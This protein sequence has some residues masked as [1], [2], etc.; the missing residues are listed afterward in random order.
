M[1]LLLTISCCLAGTNALVFPA[2][3]RSVIDYRNQNIKPQ[4]A[5]TDLRAS[6]LSDGLVLNG[7]LWPERLSRKFPQKCG[8]NFRSSSTWM[9]SHYT[10]NE[11]DENQDSAFI[12]SYEGA[13]TSSSYQR[14]IRAIE[15]AYLTWPNL[16]E[17]TPGSNDDWLVNKLG[18]LH[19]VTANNDC[20]DVLLARL[21]IEEQVLD[22]E[23]NTGRTGKYA[24][25]FHPSLSSSQPILEPCGKYIDEEISETGTRPLT[26]GEIALNWKDNIR[27]LLLTKYYAEEQRDS[28]IDKQI[29]K[30]EPTKIIR[31]NLRKLLISESSLLRSFSSPPSLNPIFERALSS[32]ISSP[33]ADKKRIYILLS[34]SSYIDIALQSISSLES[35][36]LSIHVQKSNDTRA[37]T[38]EEQNKSRNEKHVLTLVPPQKTTSEGEESQ[39]AVIKRIIALEKKMNNGCSTTVFLIHGSLSTLQDAKC[40]FLGDDS[41]YMKKNG[42]LKYECGDDGNE[43]SSLLNMALFLPTWADT[44]STQQHRDAIMD[45]W[46]NVISDEKL[47]ELFKLSPATFSVD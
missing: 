33:T 41:P 28:K 3:P 16:R 36:C 24:S 38:I 15:A 11:E 7:R 47:V 35:D 42:S 5:L 43:D 29:V 18:A 32:L 40:S 27:E 4:Y 1:N 13:V 20:D 12:I 6:F 17:S 31:G 26:V 8:F 9:A 25:K 34:Q 44:T 2:T 30:V 46:M 45:P 37:T 23:R 19:H 14:S 10:N 39:T 21:L 22:R